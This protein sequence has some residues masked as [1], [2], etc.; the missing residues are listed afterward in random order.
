MDRGQQMMRRL[1]FWD[2]GTKEEEEEEEE[3]EE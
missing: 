1:S 2:S 3:E